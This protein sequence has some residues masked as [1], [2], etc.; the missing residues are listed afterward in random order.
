MEGPGAL[1]E[2]VESDAFIEKFSHLYGENHDTIMHVKRYKNLIEKHI[3]SY[4]Y[5]LPSTPRLYSTAGRTELA[6]NHTDHNL[7]KVIAATINL[8]TIAIAHKTT[9]NLVSLESEGFPP[10][11]LDLSDLSV[12]PEESGTTHALVRGI[13]A[14]FK[15]RGLLVGGFCA[16]TSTRVL[17]GSGLSS[18]AAIEV[19]VGTLFNDLYNRNILPPVDLAII[20]KYAENVYFGKPSGLMDQIACGEGGIVGIDFAHPDKPILTPIDY[21]FQKAGY[22]LVVV[23]TGGNHANLTPDYA[24]IPKEMRSI[25][26]LFDKDV[27]RE[28]SFGE[29]MEALPA[30]R[31]KVANDRA[32]LRAYHFLS[33][34]ERVTAMLKALQRDDMH[35]YLKLVNE[36]GN[37]SF[38]FLQNL[39]STNDLKEQGLPLALAITMR[40]LNG[41]GACRVHGGGF[42]GTIQVYVPKERTTDYIATIEAVFGSGSATVLA[43]RSMST[44]RIG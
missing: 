13:A 15:T 29:F 25:A 18:S 22:D 32:V 23:D 5:S 28:V 1:L 16:H 7:G 3:K 8:D 35:E 11:V 27:M 37:S 10:V 19:L 12:I 33:E 40:F 26:M 30:I 24:A 14:A 42:A 44:A 4:G 36:S 17:K 6:G 39:Y 38:M 21:S 9:D 43:V 20:G 41:E 2:Y 34:N 31:T